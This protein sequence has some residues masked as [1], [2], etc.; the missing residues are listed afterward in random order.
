MAC[1]CSF[2]KGKGEFYLSRGYPFPEITLMAVVQT[3]ARICT[4][5]AG[6]VIEQHDADDFPMQA[7]SGRFNPARAE[8]RPAGAAAAPRSVQNRGDAIPART[9]NLTSSAKLSMP[10]FSM[11]RLR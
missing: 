10:S 9:A 4:G 5:R 3:E 8:S 11:M 1:S 6:A 2:G 7:L